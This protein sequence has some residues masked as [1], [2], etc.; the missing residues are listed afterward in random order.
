M[1]KWKQYLWKIGVILFG[2]AIIGFL[3]FLYFDK[4]LS[5]EIIE[6][7]KNIE[8]L[9]CLLVAA[10]MIGYFI[11]E[12]LS[13][14]KK[15][16]HN[17]RKC[18]DVLFDEIDQYK[19]CWG[20]DDLYYVR[21]IQIIDLYYKAGGKIDELIKKREIKRLYARVD[22]LNTQKCYFDHLTT[23][24]Y[25]LIIS[26][27]SSFLCLELQNKENELSGFW[28]IAI[29]VLFYIIIVIRYAERGQAGSY[30]HYIDEYESKLLDQKLSDLL[31]DDKLS[32]ED[33]KMLKTK[34]IVINELIKLRK[35]I[36]NKKKQKEIEADIKQIN[37]LR[38]CIHDYENCFV[39]EIYLN[40][41]TC[42]LAY[43]LEK[44]KENNYID[45]R[46][47]INEE[48]SVL[49]YILNKYGWIVY[50]NER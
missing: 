1:K 20:E 12:L 19:Y 33:E 24:L 28:I 14:A 18:D 44:G 46:N 11:V 7:I 17:V 16:I 40:G 50:K 23:C 35:K 13:L 10:C 27:L 6:L 25:S 26:V 2:F 30:R 29:I 49:Y 21:Q 36:R 32:D 31:Q 48:Y 22:Y 43:D 5:P 47:L 8:I 4:K 38:I 41:A 39:R 42:F 34:Q 15:G 3:V 45:E 37:Q 9:L